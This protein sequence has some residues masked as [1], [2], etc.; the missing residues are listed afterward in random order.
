MAQSTSA[1]SSINGGNPSTVNQFFDNYAYQHEV[2]QLRLD[3]C[4]HLNNLDTRRNIAHYIADKGLLPGHDLINNVQ[5]LDGEQFFALIGGSLSITDF[6][7]VTEKL[8]QR[9]CMKLQCLE[10]RN[11]LYDFLRATF[12]PDTMDD[13]TL[14]NVVEKLQKEYDLRTVDDTMLALE[15][16]FD[17]I[18]RGLGLTAGL[19][20]VT[21]AK[22]RR[23]LKTFSV[24][25]Q[26]FCSRL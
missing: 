4:I 19:T 1:I 8:L 21:L 16:S 17:D 23:D 18:S 26:F 11:Q 15:F 2:A 20:T 6:V 14:A 5:A 9:T 24:R 3:L 22:M 12:R 13:T 25:R 7:A 10:M